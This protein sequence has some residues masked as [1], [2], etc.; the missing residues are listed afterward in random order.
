MQMYAMSVDSDPA[1]LYGTLHGQMRHRSKQTPPLHRT[2]RR[3]ITT[4][5]SYGWLALDEL[6]SKVSIQSAGFWP[7]CEL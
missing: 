3:A 7:G 1:L 5:A 4:R 2:A 6:I